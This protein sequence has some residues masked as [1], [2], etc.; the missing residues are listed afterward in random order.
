VL[1]FDAL[2]KLQKRLNSQ[3]GISSKSHQSPQGNI[4]FIN[5]PCELIAHVSRHLLAAY[6]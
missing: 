6:I 5:D 1:S 4:F 2:Y 3:S